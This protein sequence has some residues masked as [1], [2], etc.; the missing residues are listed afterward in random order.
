MSLLFLLSATTIAGEEITVIVKQAETIYFG[1]GALV[2][3]KVK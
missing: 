1:D 2:D 3:L